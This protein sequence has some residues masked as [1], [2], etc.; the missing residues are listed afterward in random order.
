MPMVARWMI[1]MVA[2]AIITPTIVGTNG[3]TGGSSLPC[4]SRLMALVVVTTPKRRPPTL[5][6]AHHVVARATTPLPQTA[7]RATRGSTGPFGHSGAIAPPTTTTTARQPR[8]AGD[9]PQ[10]RRLARCGLKTSEPAPPREVTTSSVIAARPDTLVDLGYLE[11]PQ[12]ASATYPAASSGSLVVT[13]TWSTST[14]LSLALSCQGTTITDT[15][16][17]S[18]VVSVPAPAGRVYRD[19]ERTTKRKRHRALYLDRQFRQCRRR[20]M[21]APPR[22]FTHRLAR[23]KTL[24]LIGSALSALVIFAATPVVLAV[25]IGEPWSKHWGPG[26]PRGVSVILSGLA[27]VAWVA[28][29]A[30]CLGLLRSVVDHLRAGRVDEP[31]AATLT[32]RLGGRI[33]AGILTISA[34]GAPFGAPASPADATVSGGHAP[35]VIALEVATGPHGANRV[36]T[37]RGATV[38][39]ELVVL[40][41]GA[42]GCAAIAR[43]S[44]RTRVLRQLSDEPI[45][46]AP[47]ADGIDTDIAVTK[48]ADFDAL[49]A[50]EVANRAMAASLAATGDPATHLSAVRVDTSGIEFW[51]AE[52]AATAPIGFTTGHGGRT[53]HSSLAPNPGTVGDLPHLPIALCVG[54]DNG[55]TW[56]VPLAPGDCLTLVGEAADSAVARGPGRPRSLGV[57]RPGRRHQ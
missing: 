30:C 23:S 19:L 27:L 42:I 32:E 55:A 16:Q 35:P 9:H 15:G 41:L 5:F 13:A 22:N 31:D 57:V 12:N 25:V 14:T 44:R 46:Y 11:P 7:H 8:G 4:R 43:R 10:Y 17:N 28:W 36:D 34:L 20:P 1:A 53:W 26:W 18:V 39:P 54:E 24:E 51:L 50:F 48:A 21:T 52:P 29:V 6:A 49:A 37:E 33:A 47:T 56:L 38:V 2:V 45:A 3:R 40:G